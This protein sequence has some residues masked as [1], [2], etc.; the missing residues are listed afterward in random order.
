MRSPQGSKSQLHVPR[1][2]LSHHVYEQL[3]A[4]S[5]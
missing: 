4:A 2:V 1:L 5:A 3:Q